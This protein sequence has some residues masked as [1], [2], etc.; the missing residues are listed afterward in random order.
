[1]SSRPIHIG[2]AAARALRAARP[3]GHSHRVADA[4]AAITA[5]PPD[6]PS[7][8]HSVFAQISLPARQPPSNVRNW[9]A[10]N[11]SVFCSIDAGSA[12]NPATGERLLVPL[13]W[14]VKARLVLIYLNTEAV[15]TA[16]PEIDVRRSLTAF[17][18]ELLGR[19]PK[20]RELRLIKTQ[21]LAL[22]AAHVTMAFLRAGHVDHHHATILDRFQLWASD[23]REQ[24]FTWPRR[25]T[26]S[27]RYFASLVKH[28]IPLD[29]R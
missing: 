1:M 3:V 17:T 24:R 26:L 6:D 11:G 15:R 10:Q 7:F 16:S 2:A 14:G 27:A 4:A 13:P 5:H 22:S 23:L 9:T 18:R 21:L 19:A 28:A 25:V 29:P 20:G 12:I 8:Q